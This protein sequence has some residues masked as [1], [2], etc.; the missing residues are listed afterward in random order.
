MCLLVHACNPGIWEV[1]K[2]N[3]VNLMDCSLHRIKPLDIPGRDFSD[4]FNA[5]GKI[6]SNAGRAI[7]GAGVSE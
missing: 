4:H 2:V 6:N 7:P 3:R 1:P 5:N